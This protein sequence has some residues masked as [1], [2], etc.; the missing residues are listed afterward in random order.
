M[1]RSTQYPGCARSKKPSERSAL[2]DD[3][4]VR[5][6]TS[7]SATSQKLKEWKQ[8]IEE[9][10]KTQSDSLNKVHDNFE[11]LSCSVKF[12]DSHVL[13]NNFDIVDKLNC[14]YVRIEGHYPKG[15]V[16]YVCNKHEK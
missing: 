10:L 11:V 12:C 4:S 1:D 8:K 9:T 7:S 5:R 6:W 3:D 2:H 13:L 14:E 15:D 16:E